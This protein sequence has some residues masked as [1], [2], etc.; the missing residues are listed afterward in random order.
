MRYVTPPAWRR[1]VYQACSRPRLRRRDLAR[2]AERNMSWD[3]NARPRR[4]SRV[5][6][7]VPRYGLNVPPKMSEL[8]NLLG[9]STAGLGLGSRVGARKDW[10]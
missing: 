3:E 10:R 9:Q 6:A 7:V 4:L 1:R 2:S 5:F 8:P